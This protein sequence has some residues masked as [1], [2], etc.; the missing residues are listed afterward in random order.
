[1]NNDPVQNNGL[2]YQDMEAR[3][4]EYIDGISSE[5]FTI[6]NLVEVNNKWKAKYAELLQLHSLLAT[7]EMEQPSLRFSKNVIEDIARYQIAPATKKYINTKIIWGIAAFF[8]TVIGGFLVYGLS[9]I[10]WSVAGN[11]SAT[12]G[13][14]LGAVNYSKMF[15][16]GVM[17][18]F[19]MVNIL[20]GLLLLER[21]L[22]AKTKKF[23]E[24]R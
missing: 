14:D 19:M 11:S 12:F 6:K 1:M 13:F 21:Y 10:N 5:A 16:N 7:Q 23:R 9:Q 20:L 17:T 15:G 2:L 18:G 3:L 4:W 24:T 22:S 8:M